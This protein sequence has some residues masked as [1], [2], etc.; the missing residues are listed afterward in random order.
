MT[1]H[2]RVA[3]VWRQLAPKVRVAGVW[4]SLSGGFV[5]VAGQWKRF[6]GTLDTQ[7]ITTGTGSPT[8]FNGFFLGSFGACTDG[9][10][11][12]VGPGAI[13]DQLIWDATQQYIWFTVQ[14]NWPN[15]GWN[16]MT[17]NGRVF[18]RASATFLPAGAAPVK[19]AWRW[20]TPTSPWLGNP[21]V[22]WE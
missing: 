15:S 14:G 16:Q 20:S 12:C 7:Q 10:S 11:N 4:H 1:A 22:I 2:V 21:T 19:T 13:I 18:T 3:G 9:T 17:V 5:R 8:T 6:Y